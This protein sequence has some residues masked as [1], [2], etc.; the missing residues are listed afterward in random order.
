MGKRSVSSRKK[1][2][3]QKDFIEELCI[4]SAGF[5]ALIYLFAVLT[6]MPLY[7]YDHYYQMA[8]SKW[9]VY[10]YSTLTFVTLI[11]IIGL[12]YL[13]NSVY[14]KKPFSRVQLN[15]TDIM[16]ILYGISVIVT[17]LTCGYPQNAWLG[18]DGWY[19]GVLAQL[20]FVATYL[21]L[22]RIEISTSKAIWLSLLPS[23]I[24][25][26]IGIAQRYGHDIFHFYYGMPA[27][28]I[29]DYLSTI[30]N[31]TWYSGYISVLFPLGLYLFWL[32]KTKTQIW[33]S[34]VYSFLAF[35]A[36]V[37]NNS[38]SIYL[39]LGA[40]FFAL[41]VMSIG[42]L[43]KI[44]RWL[45]VLGLWFTSCG[46]MYVL[47][48][49]NQDDIRVLRGFSAFFLDIKT[50]LVGLLTI[51]GFILIFKIILKKRKKQTECP[52]IVR[53]RLQI[54]CISFAGLIIL[55]T[56]GII[57]L[58]TSG[59]FQKWFGITID[60]NYLLFNN[61]WGDSRG[62]NWKF[63]WQMFSE[64]SF[65]KKLF[66]IGSDCYAYYAYTTP[67]YMQALN[68]FWGTIV[69]VTNA[70]NEWLNAL[71]CHG[72]IGSLLYIG[73]FISLIV[74]CFYKQDTK[75]ISPISIAI[76]LCALSYMMHNIFCYQQI[77]ATGPIFILMGIASYHLRSNQ[78]KS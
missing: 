54:I 73:I 18:T 58:N 22:S 76:S 77:C 30:G 69:V 57:V 55:L 61:F 3:K 64:L 14:K 23:A 5:I 34:G 15:I 47:R 60:N 17:M 42:N 7:V 36:I 51:A 2:K 12:L 6:V 10:L 32:G 46:L 59:L 33:L 78:N 66:G 40:I 72:I 68:E 20:L 11:T 13:G 38:D 49:F 27:E 1:Q 31:R 25:F 19:M 50:I 48:V 4:K 71:L 70:H 62:Y 75:N 44:C 24:C 9:S 56:I 53:K 39:S 28:V 67:A 74:K 65:P 45:Y 43:E 29:R 16:V 8:F 52:P 26:I 63:T 35:S 21:I 37:T 41:F